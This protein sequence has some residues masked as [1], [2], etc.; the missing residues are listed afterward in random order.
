MAAGSVAASEARRAPIRSAFLV[1]PV[2]RLPFADPLDRRREPLAARVV[3]LRFGQPFEV[4][5]L[6]ARTE[7]RECGLRFLV[8]PERGAQIS[9]DPDRLLGC[10]RLA[11]HLDAVVVQRGRLAPPL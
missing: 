5:A 8:L 1:L 10:R 9:R 3:G 6:L 2:A 11:L 4:V 7:R